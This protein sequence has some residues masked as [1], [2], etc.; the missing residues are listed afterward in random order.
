MNSRYQGS[1]GATHRSS[2]KT[3]QATPSSKAVNPSQRT[4]A[5][6]CTSRL[7]ARRRFSEGFGVGRFVAHYVNLATFGSQR[8][9]PRLKGDNFSFAPNDRPRP[10]QPF[11]TGRAAGAPR[12]DPIPAPA[13][14]WLPKP[15]RDPS[16]LRTGLP[17]LFDGPTQH[18]VVEGDLPTTSPFSRSKACRRSPTRVR[19]AS[20]GP[21]PSTCDPGRASEAGASLGRPDGPGSKAT[22]SAC[23][24]GTDQPGQHLGQ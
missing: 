13:V 12:C 5:M 14:R 4:M 20:S 2:P 16:P 7:V 3:S 22:G 9:A 10:G 1:P 8:S 18:E 19:S 15:S 11:A 21:R 17:V 23:P 24:T 6:S